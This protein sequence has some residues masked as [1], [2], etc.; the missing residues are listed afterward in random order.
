M[1]AGRT[2]GSGKMNAFFQPVQHKLTVEA[3][4]D[5]AR[6]GQIGEDDRIELIDGVLVEMAPGDAI[7]PSLLPGVQIAVADVVE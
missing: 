4:Q 5:L 3:F 6:T 7:T 2:A 1:L